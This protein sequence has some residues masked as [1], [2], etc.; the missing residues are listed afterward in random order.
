[1]KAPAASSACASSTSW[2][3]AAAVFPC[4]LNPPSLVEVCGVSPMCPTTGI[5]ASLIARTRESIGPAPSSLTTSA[6]ASLMKRI[7]LRTASSSFTWYE[8]NGMSPTI[9]G[10][11]TERATVRVSRSISSIVTGTVV[12]S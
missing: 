11:R 7:A 2:R 10:R 6:R 9:T 1:M 5:P 4:V 8:P 3:A 12:P